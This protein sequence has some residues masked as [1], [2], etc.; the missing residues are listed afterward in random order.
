MTSKYG[1]NKEVA[2]EPQVSVSLVFLPHFA[3]ICD[4]LLNRRSA[5]W[6]LFVLYNEKA[7]FNVRHYSQLSVCL[8]FSLLVSLA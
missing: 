1:K 6:N 5:T 7:L 2:Y 4:L 3:N 8:T